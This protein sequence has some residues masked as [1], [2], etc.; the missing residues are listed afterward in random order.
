MIILNVSNFRSANARC[1][2]KLSASVKIGI[3]G[4][5]VLRLETGLAGCLFQSCCC[6]CSLVLT[7]LGAAWCMGHACCIC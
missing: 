1:P 3:I 6:R 4:C 7:G 5:R 2:R